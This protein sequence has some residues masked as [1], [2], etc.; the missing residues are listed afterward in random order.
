ME[1]NENFKTELENQYS[2]LIRANEKKEHQRYM[3]LLIIIIITFSVC[4]VSML[5]SF[6]AFSSTK[7]INNEKE[8]IVFM[9][10][11][12]TN[13]IPKAIE[14]TGEHQYISSFKNSNYCMFD[15]ACC[16]TAVIFYLY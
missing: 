11:W 13:L 16:M 4:L 5:L 14:K 2:I 7:E 15:T 12:R 1:K 3:V 8:Q 6:K 9:P 10:T